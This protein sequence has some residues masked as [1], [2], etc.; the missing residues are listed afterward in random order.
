MKLLLLLL[1]WGRWRR[2]WRFGSLRLAG[3]LRLWRRKD[4]VQRVA[5]LAGTKLHNRL[6]ANVGDQTVQ[7]PPPQAL[8]RHL[9]ATEENGGLDLVAFSQEAQYVV[10]LGVVVVIVHVN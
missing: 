4:Q 7:D 8:A 6:V 1:R 10:L 2:A 5:L 3:G 9:A